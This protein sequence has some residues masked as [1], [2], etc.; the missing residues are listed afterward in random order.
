MFK[1]MENKLYLKSLGFQII[2]F[3]IFLFLCE[4]P[5]NLFIFQYLLFS[6]TSIFIYFIIVFR[7]RL[8]LYSTI[9]TFF[10]II[11]LIVFFEFMHT[12]LEITLGFT[13]FHFLLF[14]L[15]INCFYATLLYNINMRE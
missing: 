12:V 5:I 1:N 6:F 3:S 8:P 11:Y 2:L 13:N 9:I 10:S 15:A 14:A 7:G 4:K